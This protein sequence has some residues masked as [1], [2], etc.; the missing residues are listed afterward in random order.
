MRQML[1][2]CQSAVP[3]IPYPAMN[4]QTQNFD[5]IVLGGGSAGT[6]AAFA[7]GLFGKKVALIE[8]SEFLGWC[9]RECGYHPSK[10]LR[11][12]ALLL[13]GWRKRK[14]LGVELQGRQ[15]ARLADFMYHTAN[16][17]ATERR[18][19][20]QR[21]R[22]TGVERLVGTGRFIDPKPSPLPRAPALKGFCAA[23]SCSLP[24]GLHLYGPAC[25]LS[26]SSNPRFERAA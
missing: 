9:R 4:S 1:R 20:E 12:S 10:S 2:A 5:L 17:S 13:N 24:Q 19:L 6:S 18:R 25:F 15:Q 21:A 26:R 7:S 14:V 8:R 22:E 11:E 16:V 3:A 23:I